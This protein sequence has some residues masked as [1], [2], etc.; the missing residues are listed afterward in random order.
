[1]GSIRLAIPGSFRTLVGST[2]DPGQYAVLTRG[3]G[4]AATQP[5]N[6]GALWSDD[7][8]LEENTLHE[9]QREVLLLALMEPGLDEAIAAAHKRLDQSLAE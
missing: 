7:P 3:T 5:L 6:I 4:E 9:A 8:E 1:M 2:Y